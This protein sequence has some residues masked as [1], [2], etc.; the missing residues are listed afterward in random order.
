MFSNSKVLLWHRS[1]ERTDTLAHERALLV[2][3][4]P[5]DVLWV[6]AKE[7]P[8]YYR[9]ACDGAEEDELE[10]RHLSG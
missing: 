8:Q 3:P 1:V 6:L 7:M 10:S 2:L 9:G 4:D 5:P